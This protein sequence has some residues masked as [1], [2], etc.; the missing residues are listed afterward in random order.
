MNMLE[1]MFIPFTYTGVDIRYLSLHVRIIIFLVLYVQ[2]F[3]MLTLYVG[4]VY[5]AWHIAGYI[6]HH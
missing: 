6:H 5:A 2:I 1:I 3:I 4:T